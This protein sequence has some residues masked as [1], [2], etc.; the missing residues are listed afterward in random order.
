MTDLLATRQESAGP[1]RPSGAT[2]RLRLGV[3][4]R[5]S[6]I[7]V[8]R[9]DGIDGPR[10]LDARAR[11]A[12][13]GEGG[14]EV[15]A[16]SSLGGAI[17]PDGVLL[18]IR[19]DGADG[20]DAL[21]GAV[22]GPGFRA[23]AA[24]A[25]PDDRAHGTPR[26]TLLDDLPPAMLVSNYARLRAGYQPPWVGDGGQPPKTDICAGW[27]SGG[28][29]LQTA[30]RE[31]RQ[32]ITLGPAAPPVEVAAEPDAWHEV[33]PLTPT[34][35]RRRRRLDVAVDDDTGLL[36][37]DAMF[38]DTY[39]E[40]SGREIVVHEYAIRAHVDP[41]SLTVVD[42]TAEPHVL[43]FVECPTAVASAERIVGRRLAD[44]RDEV[45]K[46]FV[47]ITTCTHLN[48]LL[49]SLEDVAALASLLREPG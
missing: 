39:A 9:P 31:G 5:T 40:A 18:S 23:R 47:G 37:V 33:P 6:T 2:P 25:Y 15:T 20:P 38:R 24:A 30:Q 19:V 3:L 45:R 17:D 42:A 34:G 44:L 7:D 11:D 36:A 46:E 22:V 8:A 4:R 26:W 32:P 14:V 43:P 21:L 12:R 35:S 28:T 13:G 48:D 10:L 27:Q 1:A 49:R 16:E 29:M 41:A